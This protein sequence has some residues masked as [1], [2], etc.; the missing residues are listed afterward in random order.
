LYDVDIKLASTIS[1]RID[2]LDSKSEGKQAKRIFFL[3]VLFI[4]AIH[5]LSTCRVGLPV[6]NDLIK[7]TP[8]RSVQQLAFELVP[9]AVKLT[10]K[11]SYHSTYRFYCVTFSLIKR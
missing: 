4:W 9:G 3:L 8:H 11:I 2:G 6:S 7:E 10:T 5:M 1:S